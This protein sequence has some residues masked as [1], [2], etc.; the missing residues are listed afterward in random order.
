MVFRCYIW[1]P[2]T[3]AAASVSGV[4]EKRPR[5]P[6][7]GRPYQ[8]DGDCCRVC[9]RIIHD[10]EYNPSWDKD[11]TAKVGLVLARECG[12]WVDHMAQIVGGTAHDCRAAVHILRRRGFIVES[13]RP[14]GYRLIG[15]FGYQIDTTQ[16]EAKAGE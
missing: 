12:S 9:A 7:C 8:T 13:R 4:S 5:C 14:T 6:Y 3:P 15:F 2:L 10:S 1:R 11:Y 16:P